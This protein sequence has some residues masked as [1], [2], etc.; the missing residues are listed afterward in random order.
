MG[1]LSACQGMATA[2]A[3][4]TSAVTCA[5]VN[6]IAVPSAS[7][8]VELAGITFVPCAKNADTAGL[9]TATTA[10][11]TAVHWSGVITACNCQSAQDGTG[12]IGA[13]AGFGAFPA[14]SHAW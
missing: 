3:C 12:A 4:A 13:G 8:V 1:I 9:L 14:A 7:S 10:E 11:V 2:L 6:P 5:A